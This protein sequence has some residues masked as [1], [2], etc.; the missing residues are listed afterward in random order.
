M[1]STAPTRTH[2]EQPVSRSFV[3]AYLPWIVAAG[4]L[5]LYFATLN[6]KVSLLSAATLGRVSGWQWQPVYVAP[7]TF[8]LTYPIRWLPGGLQL[9]A[10]NALGAI[11]A[12]LALALLARCV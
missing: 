2:M 11:C 1:L 4:M 9:L 10:A 6:T 7:L 3:R 12:A 8:L 5:G